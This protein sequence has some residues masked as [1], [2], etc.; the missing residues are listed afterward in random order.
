VK[1]CLIDSSAIHAYAYQGDINHNRIRLFLNSQTRDSQLVV[2][3]Y[4][5]DET[6]TLLKSHFGTY[7]AIAVGRI[8]RKSPLFQLVYLTPED[9]Q[10]TWQLFQKYA[11]K[12][13]SYTDCATLALMRR[14]GLNEVLTFDNHFRQMGVTVHPS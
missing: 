14:M 11:D 4:I 7:Q 10:E 6:M 1:R 8:L 5:F 3:N 13:W 2:S 12:E 9:E